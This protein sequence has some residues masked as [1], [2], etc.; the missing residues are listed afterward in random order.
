MSLYFKQL[1]Y[2][3][4]NIIFFSLV[5]KTLKRNFYFK[6]NKNKKNT[7]KYKKKLKIHPVCWLA[8]AK[9]IK[10]ARIYCG[11][12]TLTLFYFIFFF[13]AHNQSVFS[14]GI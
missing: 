12:R 10:N 6:L 3:T 11:A 1:D 2:D 14:R 8:A 13:C 4:Y 9:E 7:K 5:S